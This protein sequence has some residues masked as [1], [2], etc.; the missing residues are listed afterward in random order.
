MLT[1]IRGLT[2]AIAGVLLLSNPASAADA[3]AQKPDDAITPAMYFR[4]Q[5][6]DADECRL[7]AKDGQ[8]VFDAAITSPAAQCP[9]AFAWKMFLD[10][11]KAEF[12]KTWAYDQ[13]TWPAEPLPLCADGQTEDCCD[14]TRQTNP[15]YDDAENPAKH[16]P[17]FPGDHG[18]RMTAL[19]GEQVKAHITPFNGGHAS[20]MASGDPGRVIR[21]EMA[22]VVFR[23]KP[24]WRYVFDKNFYNTDGL[25]ALFETTTRAAANRAPYRVPG[26]QVTF[27]A[28]S[29]MFKTDWLHV[30]DAKELGIRQNDEYPYITMV[31]ESAVGDNDASRFKPGL[32][33]LVAITA[34]SKD[35]PNWHWYAME[36]VLNPGRCDYTGCNDSFGYDYVDAPKGVGTNFVPPHTKSD[37]LVTPAMVFETGQVYDPSAETISDELKALFAALGVGQGAASKDGPSVADPAWMSYRL[38][39]TQTEFTTMD[40]IVTGLGNSVT[41]GGFVQTSSCLTCHAQATVDAK[42]GPG[43]DSIGFSRDLNLVGYAESTRGP[44]DPDWFYAAGTNEPTAVPFDFTWGILFANPLSK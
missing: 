16:C 27:P 26:L 24:M 43:I 3:A 13:F 15:G 42:G 7:T 23:N 4:S 37:G 21:Q 5:I 25:A 17:Y 36:H 18:G 10:T 11:I 32:H 41:E 9:D 39:G 44:T 2:L 33:L 30:D 40:G 14:P 6:K 28:G 1:Q 34:A 29:I 22:E 8:M 12:W 19:A 38:K 31:M 35:L 20:L